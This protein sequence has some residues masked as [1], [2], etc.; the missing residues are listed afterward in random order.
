MS[1]RTVLCV[2]TED[3][4]GEMASAV[5]AEPSL[6]PIET[7]SVTE[8]QSTLTDDDV[9]AVVTEYELADG[10]GME[11]VETLREVAPQT[12]ISIRRRS[13]ISSSSISANTCQT[14]TTGLDS[15]STT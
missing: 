11:V 3:A 12:A 7:T 8:A 5:D 15:S 1:E 9:D 13:R 10:T 4:V 6:S 14:L 2:D